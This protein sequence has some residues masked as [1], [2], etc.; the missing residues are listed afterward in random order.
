MN[1]DYQFHREFSR[2]IVLTFGVTGYYFN[3]D[4]FELGIHSGFSGGSYVQLDKKLFD[5]LI[6]NIGMREEFYQLDTIAG[7]AV[8]IF[9]GD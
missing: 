7:S 6:L 2:D 3:V 1:F 8:P 4:D 9:K 5:K